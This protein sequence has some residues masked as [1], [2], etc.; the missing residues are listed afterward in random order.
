VIVERIQVED[1]FLDGLDLPFLPGLNVLIGGR[2]TGKTSI[3]ELLRFCLG[4]RNYGPNAEKHSREHA[5]GVLGSGEVIVTLL[6]GR[7]RIKVARAAEDPEPRR[8][9]EISTP[10]IFSQ[11][12]LNHWDLK[13]RTGCGY[14]IAS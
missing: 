9:G 12:K 2:G 1:G 6:D 14:W 7:N 3:I 10:S 4:A 13:P 11:L 8:S 5:L